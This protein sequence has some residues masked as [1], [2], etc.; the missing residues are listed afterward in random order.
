MK[1]KTTQVST[2]TINTSRGI[3]KQPTTTKISNNIVNVVNGVINAVKNNGN[4]NY[5]QLYLT[6]SQLKDIVAN[7]PP[8]ISYIGIFVFNNIT[9][10]MS[11]INYNE[12]TKMESHNISTMPNIQNTQL[13]AIP[14]YN[15]NGVDNIPADMVLVIYVN[16]F[17]HSIMYKTI[18]DDMKRLEP[19]ISDPQ[20]GY[21]Y[22]TNM[23]EFNFICG[24]SSY[25]P[26]HYKYTFYFSGIYNSLFQQTYR[27]IYIQ[28]GNE[29][30]DES[31]LGGVNYSK[32]S[33]WLP[34]QKINVKLL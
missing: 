32:V 33:M 4:T 12:L 31:I 11:P 15:I 22:Q 34:S 16:L 21:T 18:S 27:N 9:T 23:P 7:T 17:R 1:T 28:Y 13:L 6:I 20:S 24:Y 2:R 26:N 14:T 10:M 30:F 8:N 3:V 5:P 29:P 19:K 25:R